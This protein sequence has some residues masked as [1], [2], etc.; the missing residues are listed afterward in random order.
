MLFDRSI[1]DIERQLHSQLYHVTYQF[2][3]LAVLY[4]VMDQHIHP[5]LEFC[6]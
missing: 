1:Q 6:C 3:N 2:N 5:C 4:D